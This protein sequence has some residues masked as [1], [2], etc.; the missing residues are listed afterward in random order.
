M[1][2]GP[3]GRTRH[4]TGSRYRLSVLD[5]F[6]SAVDLFHA[7]G[8]RPT[9]GTGLGQPRFTP[10]PR[11][12][13]YPG[14]KRKVNDRMLDRAAELMRDRTIGINEICRIV[15][16]GKT[17]LYRYLT[18]DGQRRGERLPDGAR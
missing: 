1:H 12:C 3:L 8:A 5:Y 10:T 18:P 9:A 13:V 16:V 4:G 7:G 15:G 6:Q 17:T 11:L 2:G 14:R